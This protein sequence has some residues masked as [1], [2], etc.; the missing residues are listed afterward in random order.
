M[1]VSPIQIRNP[2]RIRSKSDTEYIEVPCRHC[3]ECRSERRKDFMNNMFGIYS[4]QTKKTPYFITLTYDESVVPVNSYGYMVL[5]PRDFQNF[6]KRLRHVLTGVKYFMVGEYGHDSS[7]PHYHAIIF[8]DEN[9]CNRRIHKIIEDTWTY[10]VVTAE[11]VRHVGCLSYIAKYLTKPF[12]FNFR[13]YNKG[14]DS[15]FRSL[16][17]IGQRQMLIS[18]GIPPMYSTRSVKLIELYHNSG[19]IGYIDKILNRFKL[20][21]YA[22]FEKCIDCFEISVPSPAKTMLKEIGLSF[23]ELE[24]LYNSVT[25]IHF[26]RVYF[27]RLSRNSS[28]KLFGNNYKYIAMIKRMYHLVK[29]LMTLDNMDEQYRNN[30]QYYHRLSRYERHLLKIKLDDRELKHKSKI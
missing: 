6:L 27:T 3:S 12:Q 24:S 21:H 9:L 16:N 30:Y 11:R 5:R 13:P 29:T 23:N 14:F 26:N 15:H 20:Q 4:F 22:D 7:R 17:I 2:K 28:V 10:G 1:C 8:C 25:E 18:H 19:Q